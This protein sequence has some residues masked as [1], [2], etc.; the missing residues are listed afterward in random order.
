MLKTL[1]ERALESVALARKHE[2]TERLVE[3]S[4]AA[5]LALCILELEEVIEA[6]ETE[7]ADA[8]ELRKGE[9]DYTEKNRISSYEHAIKY[10]INKLKE[11]V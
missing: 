4:R 11:G 2:G 1:K 10:A 5:T 6:L 7:L 9:L 3:M 8:E